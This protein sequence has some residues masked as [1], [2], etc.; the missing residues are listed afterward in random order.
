MTPTQLPDD[1]VS[2]LLEGFA[3]GDGMVATFAVVLGILLFGGHLCGVVLGRRGGGR[4]ALLCF[5]VGQWGIGTVGAAGT[6][7]NIGGV[8]GGKGVGGMYLALFILTA[9]LGLEPALC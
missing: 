8:R 1:D 3:D 4:S 6:E 5:L 2:A 9:L 7:V